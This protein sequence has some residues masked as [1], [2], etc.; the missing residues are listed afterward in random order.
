M[1]CQKNNEKEKGKQGDHAKQKENKDLQARGAM[2]ETAVVRPT[3]KYII[4]CLG[5]WHFGGQKLPK[6]VRAALPTQKKTVG[7]ICFWSNVGVDAVVKAGCR[8]LA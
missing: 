5:F 3:K 2:W 8:D 7:G 6:K 4:F 1:K